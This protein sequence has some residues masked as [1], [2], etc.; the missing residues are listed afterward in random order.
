MIVRMPALVLLFSLALLLGCS[1]HRHPTSAL[2]A[3][4]TPQAPGCITRLEVRPLTL[5]MAE[6]D[7]FDLALS[8]VNNSAEPLDPQLHNAKLLVNGKVSLAF[9]LTVGNGLRGEEWF[10]LPPGQEARIHWKMGNMFE[11]PGKYELV[12]DW[13]GEHAAV[14]VEVLP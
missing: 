7:S 1:A 9:M 11:G 14:V 8:A 5:S 10:A 12:L 6:L 13:W 3:D 2:N 4:P